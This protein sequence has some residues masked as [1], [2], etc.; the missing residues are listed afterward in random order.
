MCV[1]LHCVLL[2]VSLALT[3]AY[4]SQE[5]RESFEV[6][7]NP[8]QANT[9]MRNPRNGI[10]N[11]YVYRRMKTPAER[12]AEICEDFSPCRLLALRFGSQL[13]YQTYFN[14]QQHR[15]SPHLRPY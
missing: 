4:D 13:A 10:Y 15:P 2:C 14:A 1:S 7:V 3:A 12:R 8:Y 6:F 9:F 11:P 5:S